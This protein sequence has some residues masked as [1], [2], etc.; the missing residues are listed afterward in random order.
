MGTKMLEVEISDTLYNR[1]YR[2]VMD[3]EGPWRGRRE[4][5]YK[6]IRAAVEVALDQFL[7][8]LESRSSDSNSEDSVTR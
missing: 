3:K 8:S 2:A 6:A 4:Q 7:N 5:A 1:F